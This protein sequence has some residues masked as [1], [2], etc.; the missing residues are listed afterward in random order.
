MITRA[1][2]ERRKR[3]EQTQDMLVDMRPEFA[4]ALKR[5]Q[6]FSCKA[7]DSHHC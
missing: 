3:L 6:T 7:F 2:Q 5:C 1:M 4:A